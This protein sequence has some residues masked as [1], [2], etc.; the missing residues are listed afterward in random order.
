MTLTEIIGKYPFCKQA[1]SS[2]YDKACRQWARRVKL[3]TGDENGDFK[4]TEKPRAEYP[5]PQMERSNF[6]VLNGSWDYTVISASE[7]VRKGGRTD[8]TT[9]KILVPFSPECDASGVG[10]ILDRNE[11][12][13][14]KTTFKYGGRD[15]ILLHFD[16]VDEKCEVIV[17]GVS[18][19]VHEGG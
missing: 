3:S 19:G 7:Y 4:I 8:K 16:A 17:N 11:V 5:R 6:D 15:R 18:F 12:L 2:R 10:R 9:G 1:S 13:I 14:Y